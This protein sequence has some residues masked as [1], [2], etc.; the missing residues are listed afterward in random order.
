MRSSGWPVSL[1]DVLVMS[2]QKSELAGKKSGWYDIGTGIAGIS[3]FDQ[4]YAGGI[5]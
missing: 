2:A 4:Q 1:G 5:L 3:L